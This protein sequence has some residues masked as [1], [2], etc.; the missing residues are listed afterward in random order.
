MKPVEILKEEA[1]AM[2]RAAEG[3]F[4]RVEDLEWKPESG[5]N[6]MST[7]QLLRHCTEACG[8]TIRGFVEE[9]WGVPAGAEIP[10]DG[11]SMLPGVEDLPSVGSVDEALERL[12]RDRDVCMEVLSRVDEARLLTERSRP[13]WGGPEVTLFQHCLSMIWHLGQHKGQLFYYL[14]LQGQEVATW[15][16][17]AGGS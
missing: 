11:E 14:K 6:W 17:W 15:D 5:Q 7:G 16:L 13:P 3:L 8:M 9:G 1:L 2:Y 4:R 12:A 10:E